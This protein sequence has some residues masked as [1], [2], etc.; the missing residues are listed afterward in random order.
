MDLP[1]LFLATICLPGYHELRFSALCRCHVPRPS[2]VT[3][4]A[5]AVSGSA[6]G[7]LISIADVQASTTGWPRKMCT[8]E[9]HRLRSVIQHGWP[10]LGFW[11]LLFIYKWPHSPLYIEFH[12]YIETNKHCKDV[13]RLVPYWLCSAADVWLFIKFRKRNQFHHQRWLL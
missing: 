3:L 1:S 6:Q 9:G 11:I 13:Y 12:M 5:L 8:Y 7:D 10:A 2:R 4:M